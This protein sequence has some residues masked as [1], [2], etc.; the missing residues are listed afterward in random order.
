MGQPQRYFPGDEALG[1]STTALSTLMFVA[2]SSD[3]KVRAFEVSRLN[4]VNP[5]DGRP[6]PL[7]E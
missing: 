7:I 4:E 1:F 5:Q 6:I 3:V 2:V